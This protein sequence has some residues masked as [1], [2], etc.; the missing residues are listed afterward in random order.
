MPVSTPFDVVAWAEKVQDIGTRG[1]TIEDSHGQG[2]KEYAAIVLESANALVEFLGAFQDYM[3]ANAVVRALGTNGDAALAL[4][5]PQER[6]DHLVESSWAAANESAFVAAMRFGLTG[7]ESEDE[8]KTII[9]EQFE[10]EVT[11]TKQEYD[12]LV[13]KAK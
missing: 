10:E 7:N 2:S 9:R 8:A 5:W 3:L 12:D 1:D 13:A 11:K 6:L 4:L